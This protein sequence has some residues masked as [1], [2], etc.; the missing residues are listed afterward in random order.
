VLAVS[1]KKKKKKEKSEK[2][3][4]KKKIR[5]GSKEWLQLEQA[6]RQT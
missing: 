5:R 2:Q 3:E 1:V 6:T 4:K